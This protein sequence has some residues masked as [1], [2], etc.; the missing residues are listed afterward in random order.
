MVFGAERRQHACESRGG[1]GEDIP[2]TKSC[3]SAS[4]REIAM[5]V[6][7]ARKSSLQQEV[8]TSCSSKKHLCAAQT[9]RISCDSSIDYPRVICIKALDY[10]TLKQVLLYQILLAVLYFGKYNLKMFLFLFLLIHFSSDLNVILCKALN[11]FL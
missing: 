6:I 5:G 11:V 1:G 4:A 8:M 10:S 9:I 3:R 2:D 7:P